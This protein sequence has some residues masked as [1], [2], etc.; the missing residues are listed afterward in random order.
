M[1]ADVKLSQRMEHVSYP[2]RDVVLAARKVQ[3]KGMPMHW[4]N[5]GDPNRFDFAPPPWVTEAAKAALDQPQYSG[6]APSEGD[7]DLRE[8]IAKNEGIS[9]DSIFVTYGLSEGLS[10]LFDAL[11]DPGDNILLPS[12]SYPLYSTISR[13]LGGQD[14]YYRTDAQFQPDIDDLRKKI[15]SRTRAITLISPNNPTGAVYSHS[16]VQS[17]LDLAGEHG[18]PVIADEIYDQLCFDGP[19][20]PVYKLAT[21][22]PVIRGNG[23]SK[24]FFYPGARVGYLALHGPGLEPLQGALTRLCNARLSVNWE[25]QRAALAAFTRAPTHLPAALSKLRPRRDLIVRRLNA[26]EGIRAVQPQA[27]FY[28][29][30]QLTAGPWKTDFEFVYDLLEHTGI[31]GV[32]GSGFSTDLPGRFFR[33]VYLAKEPE[34]NSAM[35]KL[36]AFMKK[37]LA[38]RAD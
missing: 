11:L 9:A 34:I 36:E 22:V 26:I 38:G 16:T 33:L 14:N 18:L 30:P 15:N 12:P 35:D 3:A 4:F 23:M 19:Y 13:V 5:I 31:V 17:I 24:N 7:P 28:I 20:T 32:P 25:M 21:D 10:F 2:I 8:A 37:R 27:A 29:F 1:A 6:Y